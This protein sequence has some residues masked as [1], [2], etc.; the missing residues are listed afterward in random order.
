MYQVP[1]AL[2]KEFRQLVDGVDLKTLDDV[3]LAALA[4]FKEK[5]SNVQ[6]VVDD[7]RLQRREE[8]IHMQVIEENPFVPEDEAIFDM[9]D[10]QGLTDQQRS[11][12]LVKSAKNGSLFNR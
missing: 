6:K 12:Y 9:F 3:L 8:A 11:D 1:Q 10:N 4:A 5:Q 7:E 2:E